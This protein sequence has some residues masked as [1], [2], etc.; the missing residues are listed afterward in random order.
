MPLYNVKLIQAQTYEF[1]VEAD[2]QED[3]EHFAEHLNDGHDDRADMGNPTDYAY[4]ADATIVP[5][6]VPVI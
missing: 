4:A 1:Q 5:T 6:E 2:T 3:A